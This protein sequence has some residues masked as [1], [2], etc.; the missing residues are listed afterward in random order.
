[1]AKERVEDSDA[2]RV[3]CNSCCVK[4]GWSNALRDVQ[5]A[6]G[7]CTTL[8]RAKIHAGLGAAVGRRERRMGLCGIGKVSTGA[9]YAAGR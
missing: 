7:G 3:G 8:S 6:L 5:D 2:I 9:A 1:V 4:M